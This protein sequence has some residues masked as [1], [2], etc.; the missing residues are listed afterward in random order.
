MMYKGIQ[1]TLARGARQLVV[2]EAL[3]TMSSFF[4]S[5]FSSFTPMTNM[6][7]SALAHKFVMMCHCQQ[8]HAHAVSSK[9]AAYMP[10]EDQLAVHG[11]QVLGCSWQH[12]AR[13]T[14]SNTQKSKHHC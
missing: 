10:G 11:H 6:G 9:H 12:I 7:A 13:V 3:D 5:Y 8:V 4:G 1:P 14:G 2:Q